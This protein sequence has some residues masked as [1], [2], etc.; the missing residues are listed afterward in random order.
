M[1]SNEKLV[2]KMLK[3]KLKLEDRIERKKAKKEQKNIKK[4]RKNLNISEEYVKS[5]NDPIEISAFDSRVFAAP[6]YDPELDQ[7]NPTFHESQI[8]NSGDIDNNSTNEGSGESEIS[9]DPIIVDLDMTSDDQVQVQHVP[10]PRIRV[11][12]N[13]LQP[14]EPLSRRPQIKLLNNADR[15]FTDLEINFD[16]NSS[17]TDQVVDT[18]IGTEMIPMTETSSDQSETLINSSGLVL[19]KNSTF[20]KNTELARSYDYL[21]FS[22]LTALKVKFQ[23]KLKLNQ[24]MSLPVNEDK[25][26]KLL[27]SYQG[28]PT[29][30]KLVSRF[31]RFPDGDGKLTCFTC[32]EKTMEE[33]YAKGKMVHCWESDAC[34]YQK[35]LPKNQKSLTHFYLV[36][37]SM[38]S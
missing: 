37:F 28:I 2:Q 23:P 25:K 38:S 33:C 7:N 26:D 15:P 36:Y 20:A 22:A 5:E 1:S 30:K 16:E 12:P 9:N 14:D 31:Q 21:K 24:I 8:E 3:K 32:H 35:F 10:E 18:E 4:K 19:R 17:E 34:T 6:Y 27:A 29:S 11:G 13:F